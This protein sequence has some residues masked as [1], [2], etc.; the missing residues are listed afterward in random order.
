MEIT[1]VTPHVHESGNC[2]V[3]VETDTGLR[4]VGQG[5]LT[6]RGEAI[7]AVVEAMRSELVG[8]DPNRIEHVWQVMFRGGFFPG[9]PVQSAAV[10]AVDIALWDLKGKHLGV[11]VYELLGGR[12]REAVRC[13]PHVSDHEDVDDL[14]AECREYQNAGWEFVRWGLPDPGD[15]GV[16][17]PERAARFGIEQ[18]RAVRE[19]CGEELKICVDAHTRLDPAAAVTFCTGVEEYDPFF[20][21]DPIRSENTDKLR[22]VREKTSVPLAVG[23]QFDSKWR[24]REAIEADLLDYC[25]IDPCICGGLTEAQKVAGWCETHYIDLVPHNPGS[26][27]PVATA[28]A[29]HLSLASSPLGVLELSSPPGTTQTDLFPEQVPYETGRLLPPEEPGL[30]VELDE[31][32]LERAE[33]PAEYDVSGYEREDG[34]YTN[35]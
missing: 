34:S 22:H 6:R 8:T 29:L 30:G 9:G 7:A 18:V 16:F 24:F 14:V 5:G 4:G 3:T 23:E 33:P 10:S 21:E 2:F 32:E 19:A 26:L 28:A 35:W 25:R 13:Y 27:G 12:T 20:V 31:S 11:P 17:E 1:A 15:G